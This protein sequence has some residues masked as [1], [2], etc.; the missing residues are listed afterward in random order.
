MGGR[1]SSSGVS[2]SGKTYGTE[3]K[4][5]LTDGNIK[6][7]VK[8]EGNPSAPLETMTKNRVYVTVDGDG[9][10]KYISYYDK[11]NLRKKQIDLT[12]PHNSILPHTHHGYNHNENDTQ[13]GYS[14]LTSKEISMVEYIQKS[15]DA[16]GRSR[17]QLWKKSQGGQTK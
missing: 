15:W 16:K 11:D 2:V 9:N 8:L 1:G 10:P 13:K 3:Y 4:S 17:W 12:V 14:H 6:F 7:V 5:F